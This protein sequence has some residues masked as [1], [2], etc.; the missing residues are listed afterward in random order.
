MTNGPAEAANLLCRAVPR[1]RFSNAYLMR[2][3]WAPIRSW[4]LV[5]LVLA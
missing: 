4:Q 5:L 2:A 3:S 1:G